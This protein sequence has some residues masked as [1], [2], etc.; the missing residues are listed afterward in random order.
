MV[1]KIATLE[2]KKHYEEKIIS[3]MVNFKELWSI[4]QFDRCSIQTN[5]IHFFALIISMNSGFNEAPPT[6]NPSISFSLAN[7]LALPPV[8]EP[9]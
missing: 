9:P 7:S 6:K 1:I 5:Q 4:I 8:T 2:K 3:L